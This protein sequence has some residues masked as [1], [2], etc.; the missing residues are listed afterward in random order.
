LWC[1]D[2]IKR[3]H[4]C[5]AWLVMLLVAE[6]FSG[7]N[8][9]C[10]SWV[11]AE[12][13]IIPSISISER[14]DTNVFFAPREFVPSGTKLWDFVTTAAPQV[15][16]LNKNQQADTSISAGVGGNA[17]INNPD[18]AFISTNL[19]ATSKLDGWIGRLI[20]GAKL[21]V[22]ES[23]RYTPEPPAFLTG[24]KPPPTADPFTRG[25]QGF[26]ANTFS[27]IASA[28]GAYALSRTVSIRADYS[29]SLFRAGTFFVQSTGG[30]PTFFDTNIQRWSAGPSIRLTRGD[31][32]SLKYQDTQMD[33]SGAG[34][35]LGFTTRAVLAEYVIKTPDWTAT[36]SGGATLLEQGNDLFA[37][38]GL[39][40][41]WNYDHST[42]L[43]LTGSRDIAPAFF[44]TGGAL[45]SNTVSV[46]VERRLSKVLSIA[47][48]ANYAYSETAP[49]KVQTFESYAGSVLLK[50]LVT[51]TLSTSL[52]YTYSHFSFNSP[53]SV[54]F[55]VPRQFVMF[56]IEAKWY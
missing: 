41:A 9:S 18:L 14:Y 54:P 35:N 20:P 4:G 13:K 24:G 8:I 40:L 21:L 2:R 23:F 12:T 30:G 31:T 42:K 10:E 11:Y 51:R 15:Q 38:G 25:L 47:G 43:Q 17:F 45:I 19:D 7:L 5:K 36:M 1:H 16:V 6:V 26:R 48:N 50:Y 56:S 22:T 55:V 44:G 37:S 46:G 28:Q 27:N 53:A 34:T 3:L 49:V 29:Y 33:Q 39:V 52:S 32:L